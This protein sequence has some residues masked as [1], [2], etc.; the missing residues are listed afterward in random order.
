MKRPLPGATLAALSLVGLGLT[1]C[2]AFSSTSSTGSDDGELTVVTSLYPLQYVAERIAGD[3]ATVTNLVRPGQEPHD[4]E[5]SPAETGQVLDADL[6]VYES[7][8]QAPMD[9][10]LEQGGDIPTVDV[11][12]TVDLLPA[13]EDEHD[14]EHAEGE[15]HADGDEHAEG[16]EHAEHDHEHGEFDPHFWHDPKRVADVADA[17]ADQLAEVDPDHASTYEDNAADL[18]GDLEQL[19]EELSTGLADCQR[20]TV[21]VSHNAFTYLA[22]YGLEFEPIAGLSPD[23]EPTPATLGELHHLIEEDGL[24]TVFTERLVSPRIADQLAKDAGV[25]TAVLDPIEGLTDETAGEDYLSL[26]RANLSALK[27]ANGCR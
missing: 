26:M 25:K 20:S 2:S 7:G 3:H 5:L 19:D 27:T 6:V 9:D 16:E 4:L 21:V 10:A 17:V 8:F 15:E 14:H 13:T 24:T 18:R 12:E 11:A 22:Q 1:G 23:A